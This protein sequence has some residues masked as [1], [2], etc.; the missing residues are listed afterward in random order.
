MHEPRST[1]T[2]EPA[3]AGPAGRWRYVAGAEAVLAAVAVLADV[4]VPTLVILALAAVSLRLRREGLASLGLRPLAAPAGTAVRVL[5]LV[6]GWT[7]LQLVLI[8]P[9]LEHVTGRRQ[10][11]T[12]LGEVHGDAALLAVLLLLTWTIAAFGEEIAYRGF[13]PTRVVG[14]LGAGRLG[15]V[16]AVVGSSALFGLA[17]TE[18][19]LVGVAVTF[20]D[21]LFF[22]AL[23]HHYRSLWA[24]ILAHGFSNTI[25]LVGFFLVGPVHGL[26]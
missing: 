6:A 4:V 17:H 8:L 26:W 1:A 15:Q 20:L 24:A 10:H 22:T 23:R 21:A 16:V 14:A 7:V 11:L 5:G 25:G 13:I 2:R 9:V 19:G 18:Q 12:E 3:V